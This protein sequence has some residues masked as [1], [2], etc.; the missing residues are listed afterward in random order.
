MPYKP[1]MFDAIIPILDLYTEKYGHANGYEP[2][3]AAEVK[4][5]LAELQ[6][7]VDRVHV[8]ET[9]GE[10]NAIQSSIKAA[11]ESP[12]KAFEVF[13]NLIGAMSTEAK[14]LSEA[15]Y[16]SAWRIRQLVRYYAKPLPGVSFECIGVRDVR[17]QLIEHPE[18]GDKIFIQ[19]FATGGPNG[20]VLKVY[21]PTGTA[22]TFQDM[23]LYVN[24][25]EF[26]DSL[27]QALG[28]ALAKKP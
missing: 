4:V 7:I 26:A 22:T 1:S 2:H 8:V 13:G 24:A 14:V 5:R 23:G 20:P 19:S 9:D 12:A 25:E 21:R 3:L 16:N 11:Q 17:N 27:S 10:V 15:F 6:F 18:K 28:S